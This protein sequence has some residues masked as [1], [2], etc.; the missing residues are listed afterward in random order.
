MNLLHTQTQN[1]ES[2]LIS[3]MKMLYQVAVGLTKNNADAEVLVRITAARALQNPALVEVPHPKGALLT[4]LRNVFLQEASETGAF[5]EI[6]DRAAYTE[7][8]SAR[9][10][11]TPPA[12]RLLPGFTLATKGQEISDSRWGIFADAGRECI[13]V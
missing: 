12:G 6:K 7:E 1:M 13:G 9:S 5:G 8:P 4:L 10:Y 3:H 2:T 11:F